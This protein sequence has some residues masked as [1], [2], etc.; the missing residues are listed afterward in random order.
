MT[1][2][3]CCSAAP[4]T[5][6]CKWCVKVQNPRV[7]PRPSPTAAAAALAAARTVEELE[8]AGEQVA[9]LALRDRGAYWDLCDRYFQRR[10]ELQRLEPAETVTFK[11]SKASL[12]D[13]NEVA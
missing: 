9:D 2:R 7:R 13:A 10:A 11:V 8:L 1:R 12:V 4:G 3:K 6:W 5:G